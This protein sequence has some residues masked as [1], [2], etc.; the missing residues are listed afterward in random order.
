MHLLLQVLVFATVSLVTAAAS[1]EALQR[2]LLQSSGPSTAEKSHILNGDVDAAIDSIL[3]DFNSPGGVETRG[4][5]IAKADGTKVTSDT[6]FAIGSNSKLFDILATGLLISNESLSTRISWNTKIASVVREWELMD[7]VASAESTIVDVMSHRTGLPRHDILIS[8]SDPLNIIRRLRY[9][10]PSTGFRELWQYNNHM[11]ALLSYFP[12]L[13]V[14]IPFE[15]YVN[16]YIIEPLGMRST[17]YFSERADESGNLADGMARDGVNETEDLF[18]LGRVRALPYW[19]PSKDN[20]GHV[21]SGAGGVISSANDMA[22]WL[23]MLLGE[24]KHPIENKTIVP[25]EVIRRVAAGV[26][27]ATPVAT[28]PELSPMVYGGAQ[29]RGTY[30]GFVRHGGSTAGFRS[31]VTRIPN[32]NFG[33]AVFSNDDSF[34]TQIVESVKFRIMDE[35]LNLQPINWSPRFK[36]RIAADF[37]NRIVPTPRPSNGSLPSFPFWALAGKYRDPGYG[38]LELCLVSPHKAAII[39]DSCRLLLRHKHNPSNILNPKI[40]TFLTKWPTFGLTH[41]SLTHFEHNMFNVSGFNSIPTR[42]STDKPFWVQTQTDPT[43][44]AE[45]SYNRTL[46]IALGG[47]W[48]AGAGVHS[49]EGDTVKERAEVWFEKID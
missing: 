14:G 16:D 24:G 15:K 30:R 31:Q 49:P 38:T 1:Y 9:L 20:T 10:K 44:V 17:T 45:F 39:S 2:P 42:N 46:G 41:A 18:G 23:Q 11:Y 25:V 37:N 6:L 36:S 5:G 34:G 43:L 32:Q 28:F 22:I 27:V 40:P 26:T 12:P 48:G 19:A 3:K 8:P 33:V 21:L 13:L 47:L 7:P 4:Y 29:S 35:A